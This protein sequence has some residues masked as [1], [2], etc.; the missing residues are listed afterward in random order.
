M[1]CSINNF[2]TEKL[3]VGK[4]VAV[5]LYCGANK[6][7][8][9]VEIMNATIDA[10]MIGFRHFI[11]LISNCSDDLKKIVA[12]KFNLWQRWKIE[13]DKYAEHFLKLKWENHV[14]YKRTDFNSI[15]VKVMH[16]KITSSL[17]K[18]A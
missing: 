12:E 14:R 8:I 15:K 17:R 5:D 10:I 2:E 1:F 4:M 6:K 11:I 3:L 16:I 7:A 18:I 9:V 13:K